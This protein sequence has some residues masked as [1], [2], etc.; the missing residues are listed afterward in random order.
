MVVST[1]AMM[2]LVHNAVNHEVKADAFKNANEITNVPTN[3]VSGTIACLLSILLKTHV[4]N[5]C[6]KHI[7]ETGSVKNYKLVWHSRYKF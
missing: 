2:I 5:V 6:R 1:T 4:K 7:V 3:V